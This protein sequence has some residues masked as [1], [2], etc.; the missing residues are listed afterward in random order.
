MSDEKIT[1]RVNQGKLINIITID[2]DCSRIEAVRRVIKAAGCQS[3]TLIIQW[4]PM[5]SLETGAYSSPS[6]FGC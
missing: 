3:V 5:E 6:K 2:D 4:P 1:S